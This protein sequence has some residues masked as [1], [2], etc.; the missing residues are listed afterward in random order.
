[1]KIYNINGVMTI[2]NVDGEVVFD[3]NNDHAQVVPDG[4]TPDPSKQRD[5]PSPRESVR[6]IILGPITRPPRPISVSLVRLLGATGPAGNPPVLLRLDE[7]I[8][9]RSFSEDAVKLI[10]AR[11][12]AL[13]DNDAV[14]VDL[15]LPS[16]FGIDA[17]RLSRH[18][19]RLATKVGRDLEVQIG[20]EVVGE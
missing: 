2:R 4:A 7:S 8:M 12:D 19:A 15:L 17:K 13:G 6:E 3:P 1:M 16:H 20:T 10:K 9:E 14:H 18:L 5:P 11:V